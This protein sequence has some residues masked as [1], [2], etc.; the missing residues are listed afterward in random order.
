[1]PLAAIGGTSQ[2]ALAKKNNP[3]QCG[4]RSG[5]RGGVIRCLTIIHLLGLL[6][7]SPT[8]AGRDFRAGHAADDVVG[9]QRSAKPRTPVQ[10]C[11]LLSDPPRCNVFSASGDGMPPLAAALRRPPESESGGPVLTT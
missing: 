6:D 4:P 7:G 5:R 10:I 3:R 2:K 11:P 1:M 9:R 8:T